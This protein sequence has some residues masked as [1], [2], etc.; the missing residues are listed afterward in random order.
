MDLD[1]NRFIRDVKKETTAAT[2]MVL[3]KNKVPGTKV[4]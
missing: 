1:F 2:V 4:L 3:N